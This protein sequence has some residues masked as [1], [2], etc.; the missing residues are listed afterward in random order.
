MP[1]SRTIRKN[2]ALVLGAGASM[3]YGFPSGAKLR[4]VL[5]SVASQGIQNLLLMRE[6]FPEKQVFAFAR[7]FRESGIASIDEF[8]ERRQDFLD[9]G[10]HAIAHVVGQLEHSARLFHP[11]TE[12]G[13]Y[14]YLWNRICGN[15]PEE[16]AENQLRIITFNY[17]RSLEHYLYT[18]IVNTYKAEPDYALGLLRAIKV[19]HVHGLL[20]DYRPPDDY[21][22]A[23]RPYEPITKPEELKCA[24]QSLKLVHERKDDST[25]RAVQET[26]AWAEAIYVLGFGFDNRNCEIL[27]LPSADPNP[28]SQKIV[29]GTAYQMTGTEIFLAR[30]RLHRNGNVGLET[31]S[32]L[33][34][35]RLTCFLDAAAALP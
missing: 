18:A 2:I 5:C 12:E 23:G 14:D 21:Q 3:P 15:T 1:A 24:G 11:N 33:A 34:F 31:A 35:M 30:Q 10:R 4:E 17:D 32:I 29:Q 16:V 6:L 28:A 27:D 8:L 26:L 25:L 19:I 20:G 7:T 13:W 22:G 9:V